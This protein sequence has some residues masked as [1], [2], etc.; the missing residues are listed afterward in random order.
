MVAASAVKDLGADNASVVLPDSETA[1]LLTKPDILNPKLQALG[2]LC[3]REWFRR[4]WI[5]QEF[6]L[7]GTAIAYIGKRTLNV[8]DLYKVLRFLRINTRLEAQ[9]GSTAWKIIGVLRTLSP[10]PPGSR[11]LWAWGFID[12]LQAASC[13]DERD[14]VYSILGL[15]DSRYSEETVPEYTKTVDEVFQQFFLCSLKLDRMASLL[16]CRKY[17]PEISS[18][19][20]DLLSTVIPFVW[21]SASGKSKHEIVYKRADKSLQLPAVAVG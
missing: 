1:S 11:P 9:L 17:G 21:C 2:W 8:R 6:H 16:P 18:W 12:T 3:Q 15:L 5:Y 13:S 20:P 7:S 10:L 14:R 19:V 4:L